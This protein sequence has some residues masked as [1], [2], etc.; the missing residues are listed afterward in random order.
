MEKV[1]TLQPNGTYV[2]V[3]DSNIAAIHPSSILD[4][5]PEWVVYNEFVLT[6]KS[7]LKTV[8]DVKGEWLF[9]ANPS[10]F[11]PSNIKNIETRKKLEV[12]ERDLILKKHEKNVQEQKDH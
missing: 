3:K 6:S 1:A 10:Y 8:T 4:N 5:R 11:I 7:Y 9:D 12:I 2:T